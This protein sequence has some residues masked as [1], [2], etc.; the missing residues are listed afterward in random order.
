MV[1]RL[2]EGKYWRDESEAKGRKEED[3]GR[4]KRKARSEG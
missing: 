4:K 1:T 3:F 2:R